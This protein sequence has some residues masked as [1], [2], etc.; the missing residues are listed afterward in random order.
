LQTSWSPR[1]TVHAL[2]SYR[3]SLYD[4]H[5]LFL[6]A[7]GVFC[8]AIVETPGPLVKT[9][10]TVLLMISMVLPITRQFFL[11]FFSI[12]IYLVLFYS[13][14]FIP[15]E[16]RPPIWSRVLPAL[17]NI[18]YGA[19]LSNILSAHTNTFLD[20]LAW[21][22]YGIVHFTG[23]F[24]VSAIM[25]IFG[26][27]G[28]LRV[29]A[30]S[31]GYLNIIGVLCQVLF[32]CA[33]P[34]YE[35]LHGL[36]PPNY[37]MTGSPAGL[38]RIDALLGVDLYT[39]AFTGSPMVF[40]AMPSLHAGTAT[41]HVAF[42][43]HLFPRAK[44]VLYSYVLWIWWATLYLQHHYAVDLIAGSALA[45]GIFLFAKTKFLARLQTD[46]MTRWDYD[47]T[48]IGNAPESYG[49]QRINTDYNFDSDEW[50]VGSSSSIS[51]GTMSPADE[52]NS[53]W[54]AQTLTSLHDSDL[55]AQDVIVDDRR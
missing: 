6:V 17:E 30:T 27:P 20:L 45:I 1:G 41:M 22:P 40:G 12:L 16:M 53:L 35:N 26:A 23:P 48:E 31:F 19:N 52:T 34:W 24:V 50:T 25:F 55:E 47:Y 11:P 54:E 2:R 13:C 38:A 28:T 7:I 37:S 4:L 29:Y 9:M 39:S 44:Y 15:T 42:L 5:Y 46:K 32:P 43:A 18:I 36:E 49:L 21:F 8:L 10:I 14:R 51:S 3:W 33:P